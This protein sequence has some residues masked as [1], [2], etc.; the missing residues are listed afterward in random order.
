M[1]T[2]MDAFITHGFGITSEA[3]ALPVRITYRT[4]NTYLYMAVTPA[5]PPEQMEAQGKQAE[6]KIHAAMTQFNERWETEYLPEV[7]RHLAMCAQ[8]DLRGATTTQLLDHFDRVLA[9]TYRVW[10]IHFLMAIMFILPQSLFSELCTDLFGDEG[11]FAA[12]DLLQGFDNKTLETDRGIW[13]LSRFALAAPVVR[14]V[15]EE[16]SAA[17]VPS[18]LPLNHMP[19]ARIAIIGA[20]MDLGAGR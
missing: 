5:V 7:Q 14:R 3:Y 9:G 1:I 11:A 4:I 10:D 19:R 16:Q 6:E 12:F 15:V 18:A 17:D 8:F 2:M 13:R 20:P